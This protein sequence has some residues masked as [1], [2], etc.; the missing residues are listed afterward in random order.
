MCGRKKTL[1]LLL[2]DV[3]RLQGVVHTHTIHYTHTVHAI[4]CENAVCKAQPSTILN[5]T[6]VSSL[7]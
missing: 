3:P 1:L 4:A 5:D 6:H 7:Q 2:S